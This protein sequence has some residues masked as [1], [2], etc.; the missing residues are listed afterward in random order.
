MK[1]IIFSLLF[2]VTAL[3]FAACEQ[4][5]EDLVLPTSKVK[6]FMSGD[7]SIKQKSSLRSQETDNQAIEQGD[8]VD[9]WNVKDIN[10]VIMAEAENG[11]AIDGMWSFFNIDNDRNINRYDTIA[12]NLPGGGIIGSAMSA[13]LSTLGL[14]RIIFQPK[15]GEQ[16]SFYIRH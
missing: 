13:K 16:F 1:K 11:K 14:Y 15:V 8:T 9:V 10:I 6:V 4:S 3:L 5:N 2:A 12:T 7:Y